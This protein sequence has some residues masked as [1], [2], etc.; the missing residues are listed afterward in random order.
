MNQKIKNYVDVLFSDI[1]RTKK[2][3]ELKEEVLS[4]LSERF[5]DY[6]MEGNTENQAYSLAVSNMGDVDE[7]LA[8]VRPD[9]NFVQIADKYRKKKA[10]CLVIAIVL[11]FLGLSSLLGAA[12]AGEFVGN[13]IGPHFENLISIGGLIGMLFFFCIA[14]AIA[15]YTY[16]TIPTEYKDYNEV[17]AK[18]EK[19][20]KTKGEKKRDSIMSIY[21]L[22]VTLLYFTTSFFTMQWG[23]TWIIWPIAAIIAEIIK[24]VYEMRSLDE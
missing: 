11:G 7:L 15:I 24:S 21:W 1:P 6:M 5:D 9:A 12:S 14:G 16:T 10:R 23:R 3:I 4:N 20:N 22:V 8:S 2:A 19:I 18:D 13:F 17:V